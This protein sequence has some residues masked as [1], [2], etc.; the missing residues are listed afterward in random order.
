MSANHTPGPWVLDDDGHDIRTHLADQWPCGCVEGNLIAYV[1]HTEDVLGQANAHLIAA[2][3]DLLAACEA[4]LRDAREFFPTVSGEAITAAED[5]I[6][7]AKG[8]AR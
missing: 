2:A 4:L 1:A 6:A 7:K 8:G 5:A 3:P